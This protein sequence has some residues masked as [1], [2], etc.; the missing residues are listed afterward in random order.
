[1]FMLTEGSLWDVGGR[2]RP[3]CRMELF[4]R[5]FV[6][7]N[8]RLILILIHGAGQHSGQFSELG[9]Y[10][11]QH[12]IAFYAL[13]L[14]GFG[15]SAGK[16][17]HVSSFDE[18]LDDLD[19][20][21]RLVRKKHPGEPIFLLGHSLGGTI[22]IRYGQKCQNC[23]QGA[24]LSAPAL[25]L[26]FHIPGSLYW[27][28]HVLSRIT[29]GVCVDLRKWRPVAERIPRF[30]GCFNFELAE[31]ADPL[32]TN[33]FSVR[34]FTEL[35]VNGRRAL[36]G[37]KDFKLSVLCLCGADD[38]LI[39]P[40]SVQEFYDSLQVEDKK[41]ILFPRIKHRILQGNG[42]ELVYRHILSWLQ[43]RVT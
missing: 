35:L 40:V 42:R 10:C 18:Y 14:R 32:S 27:A 36:N 39:D 29:P 15:Q 4:Y 34:W 7:A 33:Q 6:P 1:M 12:G 19:Q 38:T 30:K 23:I 2:F 26:R 17:G 37:T 28:A 22:V 20:F 31:D 5:S 24:V 13:D 41:I 9:G 43:E 25:R 3:S 16:R 8:P 11:S 21:V